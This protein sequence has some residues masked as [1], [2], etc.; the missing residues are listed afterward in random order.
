MT[1]NELI[2]ENKDITNILVVVE[3]IN[4][5]VPISSNVPYAK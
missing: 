2:K 4:N 1:I 3:F 5:P